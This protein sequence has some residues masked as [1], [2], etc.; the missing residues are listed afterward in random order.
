M[1]YSTDEGAKAL[2]QFPRPSRRNGFHGIKVDRVPTPGED[3]DR[4]EAGTA[5]FRSAHKTTLL[6][7]YSDFESIQGAAALFSMRCYPSTTIKVGQ[8]R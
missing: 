5:L 1:D 6:P 4:A 2:V 8:T 7:H 3:G